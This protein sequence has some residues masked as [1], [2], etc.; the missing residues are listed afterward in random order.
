V[1]IA[2]GM[3]CVN[4]HVS[5]SSAADERIRGKE[6]HQFG[7]K[8]TT[9]GDGRNDLDNTMRTC[10]NCHT[11]GYLNAPR[12]KHAWLPPLH[13]EKISCQACHIPQRKVKAALVSGE[14]RVQSRYK[15][16][17]RRQNTPGLS[18]TRT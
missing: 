17:A 7:M 6:V 5:G 4:C 18:T 16:F 14:R 2:K 15:N 1:H 9:V 3:K 12:A 10:N 11:S 8:A 13:L